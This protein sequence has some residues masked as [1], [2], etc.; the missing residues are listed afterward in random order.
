MNIRKPKRIPDTLVL[1]Y[2]LNSVI[3]VDV[4]NVILVDTLRLLQWREQQI[5][6][7]LDYRDS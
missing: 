4:L 6:H 5:R 7:H 2:V 1:T 3:I